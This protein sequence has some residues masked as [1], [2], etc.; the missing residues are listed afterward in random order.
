MKN[1]LQEYTELEFLD[2]LARSMDFDEKESDEVVC[3]FNEKIKH[4]KGSAL[5]THPSMLGLEDTPESIINEIKRW[6]ASQ[7][8]PCFK[9]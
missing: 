3:F 8:L 6:Y 1:N 4:P 9:E 7:G 5:L 2:L